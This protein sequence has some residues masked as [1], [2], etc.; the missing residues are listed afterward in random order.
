MRESGRTKAM[1]CELVIVALFLALSAM[2]LLRLFAASNNISRES[3]A[4]TRAAILAQDA[5]ERFTAGET[6]PE[7][8]EYALDGERYVVTCNIQTEVGDAGALETCTVTV[9][10]DE[11]MVTEMQTACYRPERSAP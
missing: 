11:K 10:S 9:S 3:A 1:L 7:R 4:F 8:E 5:L 2:T 6:L